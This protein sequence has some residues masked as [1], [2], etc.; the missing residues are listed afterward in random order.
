M[1]HDIYSPNIKASIETNIDEAR[2]KEDAE[3]L[4]P[5]AVTLPLTGRHLIEA[6]AGTGKT[7]TLTGVMLRLIVQ[8]G[9]PCEKIIATTFTRSAAAEMRQ[10]I[11]ERLQDFYQLLQMI[12][13]STFTPLNDS[14]LD[15]SKAIAVQKYAHFIAQVQA[16]AG[17]KNLLGKY[18]D[19]INKHLIE[20]VAKQVFGLPVDVAAA[21]RPKASPKESISTPKPTADDSENST[22]KPAK[23]TVNFRIALQRTTLALNQLD[24]LFVSTLDSLCQKW[25]REYSSETGFSAEVQISNDVSSIIKGMI[26]DQI[27]AFMAQVNANMPELYPMMFDNNVFLPVDDY[28]EAVNRALNFYTAEIDLVEL[29]EFDIP[30]ITDNMH[31]IAN[32]QNP[33][34]ETFFDKGV[35]KKKGFNGRNKLA[36]NFD[37]IKNLQDYLKDTDI[38]KILD[39]SKV[40]KIDKLFEAFNDLYQNDIGFDDN[41]NDREHFKS[42][43]IV[44]NIWLLIQQQQQLQDYFNDVNYYFTQFISR[45]VRT[46]LPK[47]LESQ[48]LTTFALQLAR[49]NDALSG[50]KGQSLARYIRHQ[51]PIALIDESQDINTEQALLIQRVYLQ[52]FESDT[53]DKAEKSKAK[54]YHTPSQFLLLVGDPKQ[55]IYGFRGGD[56]QNYTTLKKLFPEQPKSLNQNHRSSAALIDSLNHWYGVGEQDITQMKLISCPMST[57]SHILWG[58]KFIIVKSLRRAKPQSW[59]SLTRRK[60]KLSAY[61]RSIILLSNIKRPI[62]SQWWQ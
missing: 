1:K 25:L 52:D 55:A 35:R 23:N 43:E 39:V 22:H 34:F 27:R 38:A 10:R 37:E 16:L 50:K 7:W 26:H 45:Y 17:Q 59:L 58:V 47:R 30:A 6:S 53:A 12:N 9:Q 8:A 49:L 5:P 20:W 29:Q 57:N 40:A 19:P 2:I 24:R 32:Y 51:Y 41:V 21:A 11:R 44:N 18:Q 62:V 61:L 56:V 33:E 46:H 54:K 13:H 4:L 60:M 28:Y 14:D 3:P 42:F 15:S 31:A 48:R 36:K